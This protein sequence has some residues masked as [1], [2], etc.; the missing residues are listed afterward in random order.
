MRSSSKSLTD[1]SR[2]PFRAGFPISLSAPILGMRTNCST[3]ASTASTNRNAASGSRP[4]PRLVFRGDAA[5]FRF[6]VLPELRRQRECRRRPP[7]LPAAK[8]PAWPRLLPFRPRVRANGNTRSHCRSPCG[9]LLVDEFLQGF[10]QRDGD[11][12]HG[13]PGFRC[14]LPCQPTHSS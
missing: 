9:E 14:L 7:A 3:D 2:S 4:L 13:P 10:G 12:C 1:Q 11:G 6:E 8:P 5:R